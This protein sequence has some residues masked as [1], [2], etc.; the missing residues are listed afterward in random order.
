MT[1]TVPQGVAHAAQGVV[2]RVRAMAP[3]AF[4]GHA[5]PPVA[6]EAPK[7]PHPLGLA[8][9]RVG[10]P[11]V[12]NTYKPP[13]VNPGGHTLPANAAPSRAGVPPSHLLGEAMR[14]LNPRPQGGTVVIDKGPGFLGPP[15]TVGGSGSGTTPPAL[16][17]PPI[18]AAPVLSGHPTAPLPSHVMP[19]ISSPVLPTVAKGTVPRWP[20]P[21]LPAGRATR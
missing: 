15:I 4:G 11:N 17:G 1:I 3:N 13:I 6:A 19:V 21:T 12:M 9:D 2:A 5:L 7:V 20:S 14:A 18:T 10:V 16:L 8:L